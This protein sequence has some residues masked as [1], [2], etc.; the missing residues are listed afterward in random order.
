[1]SGV[2]DRLERILRDVRARTAAR[3]RA[4][5]L[6]ALRGDHA[7]DPAR[8]A[9]FVNALRG[10]RGGFAL[11]A[12]CKR[13]SPSAG[14]LD[15]DTPLA[16]RALA[17][18]RG[19]ADALS[20]LTEEDHFSG[21]ALDLA[22]VAPAGLPRLRKDFLL[23][24]GMVWESLGYG[25]DAVLLI[26]EA[27]PGAALAELRACA[28]EAG[29]AVLIEAH[30]AE[31]LERAIV[32]APDC[33]GVNARDLR[34]FR[35]DLD[36]AATL[37][38]TI[39]NS[40]V[41]IAESGIHSVDD[42]RRMRA[43]GADAALVGEALMRAAFPEAVLRGWRTL[44]APPR[45]KVCG[46]TSAGDARAAVAAGADALGVVFAA[47]PRQIDRTRAFEV[48]RAAE[49]VPVI[50]VFVDA[51][52]AE[53]EAM[54]H[55]AGLA[56]AQLCGSEQPADFAGLPFPIWR[57]VAVDP[58]VGA[59]VIARWREVAA[60]FVLDHPSGPGGT[61]RTPA[62]EVARRLAALA[63]CLLAGGLGPDNVGALATAV[64]PHGVDASS[65]LE[66]APGIKDA[67]LVKEFV[68]AARAALDR[69]A[70]HA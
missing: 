9:R 62:P 6:A 48:V 58:M 49:R 10:A 66:S 43:A 15:A 50:G 40:F 42:L 24:E 59:A 69:E 68:N 27:L 16:E 26:A 30:D 4:L 64:A 23:D 11:I 14:V 21:S 57:Q 67:A 55:G 17:Y 2:P 34:D 70:A 25:A 47:S 19:G 36:R 5:P 7:P 52:R 35:V 20:V 54:V 13:S 63:P 38:A 60:L 8:R 28:S 65:R 18:A 53:V 29:L 12:E 32:V 44:L 3:R 39:P 61:G 31:Q 56:G 1:M 46:I 22:S 41:R 33:V 45:I 37:L 51:S